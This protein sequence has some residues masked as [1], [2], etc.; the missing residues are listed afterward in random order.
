MKRSKISGIGKYLPEKI[1]TNSD[2]EKIMDTTDQWIQERTGIKERRFVDPGKET[3][4]WMG[5]QASLQALEM[6]GLKTSDV[7]FINFATL[8]PDY[9]FPGSGCPMQRHWISL[10]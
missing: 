3:P 5:A 9:H 6:A 7:D 8:S 10:E 1:V 4:S 2:L